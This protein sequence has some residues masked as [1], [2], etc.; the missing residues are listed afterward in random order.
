M[1]DNTVVATKYAM[2]F[3]DAYE[4]KQSWLRGTVTTQ[5][6]VS[7][8]S[9]VFIIE[10]VAD[11]AVERGAGGNIPYVSDDQ[12]SATCELKEYH[13]LARKNRFKIFSAS[14]DNRKSMQNRGM[15][16]INLKTDKLILAQLETATYQTNSGSAA[17]N[18]LALM[19][20]ATSILDENYVPDDGKRYGLLTPRAYAQ[21]MRINQFSSGDWVPDRPFMKTNDQWRSWNG[22]KWCKHPNL[23]GKTTASASCFLYHE[24]SV[25]HAL[26]RG[27][28]VV[29][30]G[31][32]EEQDYSWAR[33]T[34]YQGAKALQAAGIVEM[35]HNDTAALS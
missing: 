5:G 32:D 13:H 23:P 3:T 29:K 2:E 27:D 9:F 33:V 11:E 34:S 26:N 15:V 16:S 35:L 4:Q 22:V 18:S 8:G 30:V 31:E 21:A 7:A 19:L 12:T 14:V 28:M 1:A 24:C 20:E 6:E 25:G 10:G 17:A